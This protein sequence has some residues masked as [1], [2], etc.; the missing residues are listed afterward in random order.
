MKCAQVRPYNAEKTTNMR[1][2]N[3]TDIDQL[4]TIS[5]MV[6]R[7]SNIIPEM[8]EGM[9]PFAHGDFEIRLFE[10]IKISQVVSS[11]FRSKV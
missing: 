10:P 6:I 9:S 3:P 1:T 7:S 4:I 2:L 8:T 11:R 5:G